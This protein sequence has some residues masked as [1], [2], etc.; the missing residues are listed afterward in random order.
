M[1]DWLQTHH[2]QL[3]S[4]AIGGIRVGC[5]PV[6]LA[7]IR[8]HWLSPKATI[9]WRT[10]G[11]LWWVRGLFRGVRM[12]TTAIA[13]FLLMT[14]C[15]RAS[16][17]AQATNSSEAE[18]R[19]AMEERRKASQQG[20]TEKVLSS[21]ADEYLQTDIGGYVQDKSTWLNEYFKPLSELIKAGKF[22]WE[23][24]EQKDVRIRMYGDCAVIVGALEAKGSG[25]R[26]VPIQH[27]WVADPNASFSGTLRFT[28]VYIKRNGRWLLAA[29]HNAVPVSPPAPSK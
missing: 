1:N 6:F 23:V 11:M 8:A 18:V 4:A 14:C 10:S 5:H 21:L 26:Y 27:A 13:V 9:Q 16:M 3:S 24:Y 15:W 29:L 22:R 20:D 17:F 7:S 25:A 19:A 28:H 12:K 2:H